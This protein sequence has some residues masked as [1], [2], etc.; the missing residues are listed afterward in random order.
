MEFAEDLVDHVENHID[1]ENHVVSHVVRAVAHVAHVSHVAHVVAHVAH[2]SHVAHV[3]DRVGRVVH[4]GDVV[5]VER[6]LRDM[7]AKRRP[8]QRDADH[9]AHVGHAGKDQLV[10]EDDVRQLVV[11]T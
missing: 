1:V 10:R 9:A 5:T 2:V 4:A 6:K 8:D 11:L 7:V 3:V